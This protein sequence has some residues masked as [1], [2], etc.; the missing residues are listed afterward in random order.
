MAVTETFILSSG[1]PVVLRMPNMYEVLCSIGN[2]PT[3]EMAG[4]LRLLE[5]SNAI[6]EQNLLQRY[7]ALKEYFIGLYEMA[8]LCIASPRVRVKGEPEEGE[9]SITDLSF[10]DVLAIYNRFFF[11]YPPILTDTGG[12]TAGVPAGDSDPEGSAD[13][14]PAGDEVQPAAKRA[15]RRNQPR[16]RTSDRSGRADGRPAP[17]A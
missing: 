11:R 13:A 14:G 6:A 2:V 3:L 1:R 16:P 17:R 12:V 7:G 4:V 10:G 8:R 15:G 9:I 5:G